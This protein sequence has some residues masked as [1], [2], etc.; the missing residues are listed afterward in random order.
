LLV[1]IYFDIIYVLVL[2]IYIGTSRPSLDPSDCCCRRE[3]ADGWFV[4]A[5]SGTLYG[6]GKDL[7]GDRAGSFEQGDRVGVLL[8]LDGGSLRFFRNGAQHGPGYAA[9]SATGP[10]VAAVQMVYLNGSVRLQPTKRTA[11]RV[12][13]LQGCRRYVS[14]ASD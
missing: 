10:V 3:C 9:G 13:D 11:A 1:V 12:N 7:Y 5:D 8:G 14:T 6:N 2:E 4:R